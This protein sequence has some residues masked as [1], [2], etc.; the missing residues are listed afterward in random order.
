MNHQLWIDYYPHLHINEKLRFYGDF[1]FRVLLTDLQW[2][3]I[4]GR[5]SLRYDVDSTFTLHGGLGAF[6]EVAKDISNRFELRPWQ[7]L[8]VRWPNIRRWRF[9]HLL[10]LEERINYLLQEEE[11]EF[12]FRLR[13]RLG[14]NFQFDEMEGWRSFFVPFSIEWFIPMAGSIEEVF[15]DRTQIT[16]GL[17]YNASRILQLRF[18]INWRRSR[19]GLGEELILS[20]WSYRIQ[21]R[22]SL[23]FRTLEQDL[24]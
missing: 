15:I 2:F 7:G 12:E 9:N 19:S 10:R 21:V 20:D 3:R 8:Q 23:D 18:Q 5:P 11:M 16:S 6:Y 13:V 24:Q 17:G 22:R 14:G 4:Y 1:G